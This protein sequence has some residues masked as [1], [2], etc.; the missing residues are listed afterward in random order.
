MGL[1]S[2][3]RTPHKILG[4]RPAHLQSPSMPSKLIRKEWSV[5]DHEGYTKQRFNHFGILCASTRQE[6]CEIDSLK[7][8]KLS[9]VGNSWQG[10]KP[11]VTQMEK[12]QI[13]GLISACQDHSIFLIFFWIFRG[14]KLSISHNPCV[15]ASRA[16]ENVKIIE[17]PLAISHDPCRTILLG[18]RSGRK[19]HVDIN[20]WTCR[21]I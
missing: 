21:N 4:N 14:Y 11:I 19:I 1:R 20:G 12:S 8:R 3:S 2:A 13:I 6:L 16:T 5:L 9:K 17:S 10:I 18:C 15:L 7:F